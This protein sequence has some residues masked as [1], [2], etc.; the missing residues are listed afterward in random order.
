MNLKQNKGVVGVDIAIALIVLMILIPLI[1]GLIFNVNSSS[2]SAKTKSQALNIAVN[3]L[4]IAN[5]IDISELTEE[6]VILK[7]SEMYGD[8]TLEQVSD[9]LLLE[10]NNITYKLQVFITDYSETNVDAQSNVVKTVKAQVTYNVSNE[11]ESIDI[12]TVITK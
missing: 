3:T 2:N 10:I 5:E 12:S 1:T 9:G 7:I 4:E 6:N 11:E 8:N